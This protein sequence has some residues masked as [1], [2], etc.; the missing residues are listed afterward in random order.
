MNP[1]IP[2]SLKIIAVEHMQEVEFGK[3][4]P[5]YAEEVVK[6]FLRDSARPKW[7]IIQILTRYYNF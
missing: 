5:D 1:I 6:N 2:I 3:L 4:R 7:H